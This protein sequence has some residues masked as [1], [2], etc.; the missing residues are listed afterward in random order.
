VDEPRDNAV[1]TFVRMMRA[2]PAIAAVILV[3]SLPAQQPADTSAKAAASAAPTRAPVSS[4]IAP[5]IVQPIPD[6][7]R[8]LDAELRMALFDVTMDHP[9]S[10]LDRLEW[11]RSSPVAGSG[12]IVPGMRAQEDL[13]FLLAESYYRL[14]MRESFRKTAASLDSAAPAGRYAGVIAAQRMLDAYTRG[15]YARVRTLASAK[16]SGDRGLISLV[17]GLAAVQNRD[18][19]A[20]H[21]AFAQAQT[22]GGQFALYAQYMDA[23]ATAAGDSA[24]GA[25]ALSHLQALSEGNRGA[26]SEQVRLS[27]A[28][29]AL[30]IGQFAAAA[31]LADGV[32]STS[33][34][35]AQALLTKA[36]ALYRGG[37]AAGAA[38]A[39]RDFATRY[40]YLPARDEAR[41]MAGQILLESGKSDSAEKY[42]QGIADSIGGELASLQARAASA[43]TDASRALVSARVAGSVFIANAAPGKIISLPDDAGAEKARI[44]AAFSGAADSN[45]AGAPP[46]LLYNL[47]VA[48]RVDSA[49]GAGFPTRV[50]FAPRLDAQTPGLYA[51][52]T[53]AV[54]ATDIR[55][56]LASFRLEEQIDAQK[57]KIA[58]LENL[59]RLIVESDSG[60]AENARQIAATQDSLEKMKSVLENTREKVRNAL[61]TQIT[62]TRQVAAENVRLLDSTK[63]SLG[64]NAK[65]PEIDA[66]TM[67]QQTAGVYSAIADDIER[68][69]EAALDHHPAFVLR[70]SLVARLAHAHALHDT[71]AAVLSD[72]SLVVANELTAQRGKES[73]A[74]IAMRTEVATATQQ[75]TASEGALVALVDEELRARA[76]GL[77][78]QLSHDHEAA[79][80]ATASAAFFRA[81]DASASPPGGASP[82]TAGT[83]SGGASTPPRR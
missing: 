25:A 9:L 65:G 36:W 17:A 60:L 22:A 21:A 70:D 31:S 83:T 75:R 73:N 48:A 71:T 57:T 64:A 8:G 28:Q 38:A 27:A 23:L 19:T 12:A 49:G 30:G 78:A 46:Q 66:L 76:T 24:K 20:A 33:G 72:D 63:A 69:L 82:P 7:A 43:M 80:Y 67:E 59:Q 10:A 18:F 4:V 47:G 81:M 32:P 51:D 2:L 14:G 56:A 6:Q 3:S 55:L 13:L 29:T 37:N 39:F 34:A 5:M 58:A 61:R 62:A 50:V 42:F 15:D 54:L 44:A 26:F 16:T 35:G 45:I 40:P 11:L 79:D 41:L 1:L 53:Q 68:G 77:V 74:V 52:R